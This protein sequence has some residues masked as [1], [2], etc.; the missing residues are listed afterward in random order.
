MSL[1][2]PAS[3]SLEP[4]ADLERW[5]IREVAGG[6]GPTMHFVGRIVGEDGR[7]SS[8]IVSF[9]RRSM[10]G[11]TRSG[12]RYRLLGEPG[13]DGDAEYVWSHWVRIN[14][15][16]EWTAATPER[17]EESLAGGRSTPAP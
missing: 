9:D 10:E 3:P 15:V 5:Q 16:S 1:Y 13:T 7:V 6:N 4:V 14:G 11:V 8:R 12:R 17:L 2:T